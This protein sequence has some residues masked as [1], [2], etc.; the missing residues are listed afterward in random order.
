M[1]MRPKNTA[2][3]APTKIYKVY[4]S[5]T[6]YLLTKDTLT[7]TSF[8]GGKATGCWSEIGNKGK[9]VLSIMKK[10]SLYLFKGFTKVLESSIEL[11]EVILN[12]DKLC[13]FNQS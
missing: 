10:N 12:K 5:V 13:Y 3:T 6:W 1:R 11:K 2:T 9:S 7:M 8:L 4:S